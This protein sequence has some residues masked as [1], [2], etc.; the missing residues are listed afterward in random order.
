MHLGKALV[1]PVSERVAALTGG[2]YGQV[3]IGP[4]LE[5]A[6]IQTAGG[7]RKFDVLSVGTC[8]PEH[9]AVENGR[10]HVV[11]LSSCVQRRTI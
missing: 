11:G 3:A 7:D 2:R 5:A 9:Y 8:H 1:Q 10:R 4:Q 6:G